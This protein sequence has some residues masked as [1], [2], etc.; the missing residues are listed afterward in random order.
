MDAQTRHDDTDTLEPGDVVVDRDPSYA[1]CSYLL[2]RVRADGTVD[3]PVCGRTAGE[4][5]QSAR[6]VPDGISG[7]IDRYP[8][9]R[10]S[11]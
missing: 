9:G 1:P 4:M 2:Y 5:I 3:C 10:G 8:H 11:A 7:T 6:E